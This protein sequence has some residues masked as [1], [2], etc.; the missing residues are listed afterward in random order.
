VKFSFTPALN[1]KHGAPASLANGIRVL[2]PRRRLAFFYGMGPEVFTG[3]TIVRAF[4]VDVS[5]THGTTDEQL[6]DRFEIDLESLQGMLH[7]YTD[8][9]RH[10]QT[11]EKAIAKVAGA[12]EKMSERLDTLTSVAGPTGLTVSDS[13]LRNVA[14]LA[15]RDG[16]KPRLL[17]PQASWQTFVE[18][19]EV[20][21][22]IAMKLSRFFQF[23]Q[24]DE[25]LSAI[26]GIDENVIRLLE[27][28]FRVDPT[29][30]R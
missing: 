14:V 6:S 26:N 13:T 30:I 10:G 16:F 25:K 9:E 11:M 5:Y 2:P 22:A 7:Q 19:L 15:G 21:S 20:D 23:R 29:M 12:L 24:G 18:V 8:L 1:W 17:N 28:R 4:S 27:S 3:A